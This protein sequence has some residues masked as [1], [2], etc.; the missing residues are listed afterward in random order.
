MNGTW[1][2]AARRRCSEAG[3]INF[4]TVAIVLALVIGMYAAYVFVPPYAADYS[5]K[6]ELRV[7]VMNAFKNDND[8]IRNN[9][10]TEAHK[11]GINLEEGAWSV[12][13]DHTYIYITV[14]YR[15]VVDLPFDLDRVI[16]FKHDFKQ[17]IKPTQ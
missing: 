12:Y 10:T 11:L 15:Q 16:V 2:H 7:E 13:R 4:V 6:R 3:K 8:A 5:F 17:E 9:I 1:R 14:R